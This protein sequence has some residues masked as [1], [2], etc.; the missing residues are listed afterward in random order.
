MTLQKTMKG[1]TESFLYRSYYA[2]QG[3][4]FCRNCAFPVGT[5]FAPSSRQRFDRPSFC[6]GRCY[7]T[8]STKLDG[9]PWSEHSL[10]DQAC[11][12]LANIIR[13]EAFR[14]AQSSGSVVAANY[15]AYLPQKIVGKG[16][17]RILD[18]SATVGRLTA[19][20][21]ICSGLTMD[22]GHLM[23][24]KRSEERTSRFQRKAYR[25]LVTLCLVVTFYFFVL[26]ELTDSTHWNTGETSASQ[27][28]G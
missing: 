4:S 8:F 25:T 17:E 1:T 21:D 9:E 7:E 11:V 27:H 6:S 12:A 18:W 13:S 24:A 16:I 26:N 3:S 5:A 19:T 22:M 23:L 2:G 20:N 14:R 28:G 15:D 10:D